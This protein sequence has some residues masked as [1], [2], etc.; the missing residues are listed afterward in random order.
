MVSNLRR[1]GDIVPSIACSSLSCNGMAA[2]YAVNRYCLIDD[3][4][5]TIPIACWLGTGN[6]EPGAYCVVEVWRREP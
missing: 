6:C 5:T 3:V 2:E 1:R 4:A